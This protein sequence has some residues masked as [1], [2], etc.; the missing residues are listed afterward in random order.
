MKKTFKRIV[1]GLAAFLIIVS[2]ALMFAG[3][4]STTASAKEIDNGSMFV[5]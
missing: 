1:A 2:I 4:A 5:C 3:C